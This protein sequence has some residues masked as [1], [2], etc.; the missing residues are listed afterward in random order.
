M[1]PMN[2]QEAVSS[3][4]A[5]QWI[6]AMNEEMVSLEM[7]KTWKSVPLPKGQKV[8]CTKWIY[9]FK[10]GISGVHKPRFKGQIGC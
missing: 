4:N 5:E 7:N 2:F 3:S 10:E 9:K 8:I 1:E 6:T